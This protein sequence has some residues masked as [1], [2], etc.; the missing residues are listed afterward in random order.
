MVLAEPC[1]LGSKIPL[2]SPIKIKERRA[3]WSD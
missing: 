1:F 2:R 3:Y